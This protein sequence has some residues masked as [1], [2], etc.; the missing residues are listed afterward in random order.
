[1]APIELDD[2]RPHVTVQGLR[3]VHVFPVKMLEKVISGELKESDI[4]DL[5][6]FIP[7]IIDEW[8]CFIKKG[9]YE[10]N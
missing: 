5:D 7:K 2:Y 3:A 8:L 6:D 4:E 10:K 1:M 9:N